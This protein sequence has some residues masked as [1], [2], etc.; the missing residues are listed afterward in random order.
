M[1]K[2]DQKCLAMQEP[3]THA[4]R[5]GHHCHGATSPYRTFMA[6]HSNNQEPEALG[7]EIDFDGDLAALL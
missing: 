5:Q 4:V 7:L 1:H 2:S 6:P 3:S